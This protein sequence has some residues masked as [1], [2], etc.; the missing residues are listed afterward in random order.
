MTERSEEF[1]KYARAATRKLFAE[2]DVQTQRVSLS[3]A[4]A[5]LALARNEEWLAGE[6]PPVE[7]PGTA[8]PE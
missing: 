4:Q 8:G 7:R 2:E 1:R 6:V 3:L 5:C